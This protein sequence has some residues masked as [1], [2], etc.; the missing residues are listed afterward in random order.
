MI[1]I[2][3]YLVSLGIFATLLIIL[4]ALMV[5][6]ERFHDRERKDLYDRIMAGNYQ[7]YSNSHPEKPPPMGRNVLRRGLEKHHMMQEALAVRE[8]GDG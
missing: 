6:R 7:E 4:L 1:A 3:V 2:K 8:E 5:V